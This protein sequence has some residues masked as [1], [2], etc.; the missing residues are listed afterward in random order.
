MAF[1]RVNSQAQQPQVARRAETPGVGVCPVCELR[2]EVL[3][4]RS[5]QTV[6][7]CANCDTGVT[8]FGAW[9]IARVN[10]NAK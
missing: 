10:R 9:T 6:S 4:Q 1:Q 7:V 3:Y 2:M 5:N 8:A